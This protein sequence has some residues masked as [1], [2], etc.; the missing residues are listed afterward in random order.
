MHAI[1]YTDYKTSIYLTYYYNFVYD[2]STWNVECPFNRFIRCQHK[3]QW[4]GAFTSYCQIKICVSS[5]MNTKT[6]MSI[7][8]IVSNDV[9]VI[10]VVSISHTTISAISSPSASSKSIRGCSITCSILNVATPNDCCVI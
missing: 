2:H 8:F 1:N 9:D 5:F 10:V 7:A 4:P 3:Y 6:T